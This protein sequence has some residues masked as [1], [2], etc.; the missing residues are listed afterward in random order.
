MQNE[1]SDKILFADEPDSKETRDRKTEKTSVIDPRFWH[2]LIVDDEE[3]IHTLTSMML[4]DITFAGRKV[5]FHSAYSGQEAKEF[6]VKNPD[7][8]LVLLDVMMET[9]D[10]GIRLISVIR[11]EL[12]NNKI[13]IILRTGQPGQAPEREVIHN[14]NINGYYLK[15][16]ITSQK[17]YSILISALRTYS[18]IDRLEENRIGLSQIINTS[19]FM[20][21]SPSITLFC[22]SILTQFASILGSSANSLICSESLSPVSG[23]SGQLQIIAAAG[24]YSH[25]SGKSIEALEDKKVSSLIHKASHDKEHQFLPTAAC[26]YV[27]SQTGSEMIIYLSLSH[28]LSDHDRQMVEIFCSRISLLHE[29]LHLF[30]NT[31]RMAY[32]DALTELPNR[33]SFIERLES[34]LD[35]VPSQNTKSIQ[36]PATL[37]TQQLPLDPEKSSDKGVAVLLLGLDKFRDINHTFSHKIGDKI[38]KEV[39]HR[40]Q[41]GA[42]IWT[43]NNIQISRVGG[44]TFGILSRMDGNPKSAKFL[45]S[46]VLSVLDDPININGSNLRI[47]GSIGTVISKDSD[48]S[49]KAEDLIHQAD[50]AMAQAKEIGRNSIKAYEEKY[51]SDLIRRT[52]IL[53]DLRAAIPLNELSLYYQPQI[54]AVTMEIVGAEALLRWCGP[55]GKWVNPE[56]FIPLAEQAGLITPIGQWVLEEAIKTHYKW[57]NKGISDMRMAVNISAV[58]LANPELPSNIE[59]CLDKAGLNPKNLEIEVTETAIMSEPTIALEALWKI[60]EM[61]VEISID[62]FGTG[63]TSMSQLKSIP[64][65]KLKIDRSFVSG[66]MID[67]RDAAITKSIIQLGKAFGM[68]V[69]AEGVETKEQEALLQKE[70]CHI[71][72]GYYYARPMPEDKML[73][74]L[75]EYPRAKFAAKH[76]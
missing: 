5:K 9:D 29:N 62:D 27:R 57:L 63:T 71:L 47:T 40:L 19:E 6:L 31:R 75:S 23:T 43:A 11:N 35:Y 68:K 7:T 18:Y 17:L 65:Q 10:A 28:P 72:Q 56:D 26:L 38:L 76:T 49:D 41:K 14:Y 67:D 51:G 32:Y 42:N 37:H 58:Q 24:S 13:Q 30:T 2:I 44:D 64:A 3:D 73:T 25:S 54:D 66:A 69:I 45:A 16:E 39:A 60:K 52:Q 46:L 21:K 48:R 33:T 8:A 55:S 50:I 59:S 22:N 70:G 1:I 74:F 36:Q 12:E 53:Q 20:M 4:S 34:F 15:T 61:G